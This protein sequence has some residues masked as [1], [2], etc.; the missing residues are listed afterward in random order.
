MTNVIFIPEF[1]ILLDGDSARISP[2]YS[3]NKGIFKK[4]KIYYFMLSDKSGST[5]CLDSDRDEIRK[6][7]IKIATAINEY[8]NKYEF[9]PTLNGK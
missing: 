4:K 8:K 9:M 3:G 1:E 6:K 2:I 5:K 7:W